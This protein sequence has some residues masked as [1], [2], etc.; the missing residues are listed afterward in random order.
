MRKAALLVLLLAGLSAHAQGTFVPP[1]PTSGDNVVFH[2][3][4]VCMGGFET[5]VINGSNIEVTFNA[6]D[7]CIPFPVSFDVPLGQ[8][9]AGTYTL[10]ARFVTE[11]DGLIGTETYTL[12]VQPAPIPAL[13]PRSLGL[14]AI[15]L[16][17]A[18]IFVVR[19]M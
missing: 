9:P 10:T 15:G 2:Y 13:D 17:F 18:A 8:L 4:G 6:F 7:A 5:P 11:A 14:L 1:F 3:E 12:Q 16:A 19:R